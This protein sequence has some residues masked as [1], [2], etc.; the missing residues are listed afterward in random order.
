MITRGTRINVRT[1]KDY[2]MKVF[3]KNNLV[4]VVEQVSWAPIK[5]AEPVDGLL[6]V[7]V[8]IKFKE[9]SDKNKCTP[10]DILTLRIVGRNTLRNTTGISETFQNLKYATQETIKDGEAV[11]EVPEEFEEGLIYSFKGQM[12]VAES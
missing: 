5:G 3:G 2:D 10:K 12:I 9:I 4:G 8:S 6:D 1:S 11:T 7:G